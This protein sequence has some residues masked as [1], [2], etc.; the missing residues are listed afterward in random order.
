MKKIERPIYV[1]NVYSFFNKKEP[2]KYTVE[3]NLGML[4]FE[5]YN[6]GIDWRT[7]EVKMMR[8]PEKCGKQ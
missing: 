3:V 5:C 2:I 1:R 4:W 8:C 7:G 6:P